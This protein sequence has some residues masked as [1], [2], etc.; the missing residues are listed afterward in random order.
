MF[1]H[2]NAQL[3][4][5]GFVGAVSTVYSSLCFLQYGLRCMLVDVNPISV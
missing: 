5:V 4:S 1:V 2:T 3:R